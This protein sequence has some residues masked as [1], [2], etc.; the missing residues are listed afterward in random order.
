MTSCP[1]PNQSA[2]H[3]PHFSRTSS[4]RY[5]LKV[6]LRKQSQPL[7]VASLPL[8]PSISPPRISPVSPPAPWSARRIRQSYG[9]QPADS[10]RTK[11]LRLKFAPL[12]HPDVGILHHGLGLS[13][14]LLHSC[15]RPRQNSQT[16]EHPPLLPNRLSTTQRPVESKR[17]HL[18]AA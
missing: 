15:C 17:K 13:W 4:A 9:Y 3:L 7:G 8:L 12:C 2:E 5:P 10:T 18:A 6:R 1:Q 14:I 11:I 16:S